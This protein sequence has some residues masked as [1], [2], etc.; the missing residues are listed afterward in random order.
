VRS[1]GEKVATAAVAVGEPRTARHFACRVAAHFARRTRD[2]AI[3]AVREIAAQIRTQTIADDL[4]SGAEDLAL[5]KAADLARTAGDAA[6]AAV[7]RVVRSVHALG[8]AHLLLG[9]A[10]GI[11]G[12]GVGLTS[13]QRLASTTRDHE[14]NGQEMFDAHHELLADTHLRNPPVGTRAHSRLVR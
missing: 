12:T 14:E 7:A 5:P 9:L 2:A 4:V 1:V 3:T 10:H 13:D 6:V 11:D 8:A